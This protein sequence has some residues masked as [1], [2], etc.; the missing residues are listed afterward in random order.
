M[1]RN[2]LRRLGVH[3][4]ASYLAL[5]YVSR[6]P[7]PAPIPALEPVPEPGAGLFQLVQA[8]IYGGFAW[9]LVLLVCVELLVSGVSKSIPDPPVLIGAVVSGFVSIFVALPGAITCSRMPKP[10]RALH[11]RGWRIAVWLC[12]SA[13]AGVGVILT[14]ACLVLLRSLLGRI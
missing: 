3:L 8:L 9:L 13:V 5:V 12:Y 11:P 6:R 2:F 4:Q 1:K 10:V 14:M 7:R